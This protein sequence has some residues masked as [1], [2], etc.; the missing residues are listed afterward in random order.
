MDNVSN[1]PVFLD[2][3]SLKVPDRRIYFRIG[4][5]S[6]QQNIPENVKKMVR[7][8]RE[9]QAGIIRPR[10]VYRIIDY[11]ETNRHPIFAG[12]VKTALCICTIG[13]ELEQKS[14]QWMQQNQLLK[15]FILD[16][17]G[18]EAAEALAQDCDK[19]LADKALEMK[20]WPS[21]RFSPGY[22]QWDIREQKF[23]FD[24]LP[25]DKIGV[26]LSESFMMI[27]RKSVSFRINFYAERSQTTRR[28]NSM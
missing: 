20:L 1:K 5:K 7:E 16:S 22:G 24:M 12:A 27:P 2:Q 26:L 28:L 18:S 3:F 15:G 4:Y 19:I 21:K 13:Q 10:A 14:R 9:I 6:Q 25:A 17:F 8:I 11:E 23:V